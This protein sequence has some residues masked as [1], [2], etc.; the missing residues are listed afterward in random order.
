MRQVL[1]CDWN[2]VLSKLSQLMLSKPYFSHCVARLDLLCTSSYNSPFSP[3]SCTSLPSDSSFLPNLFCGLDA[4][5]AHPDLV[6][7]FLFSFQIREVEPSLFPATESSSSSTHDRAGHWS[8]TPESI[9]TSN[10]KCAIRELV[11]KRLRE[12]E[13]DFPSRRCRDIRS[14][15]RPAPI[16]R[17]Y[18]IS[19][20]FSDAGDVTR[21]SSSKGL[22][23]DAE[24]S[25]VSD[26][27]C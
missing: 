15:G 1:F 20:D 4:A 27:A 8:G 3:K 6:T 25:E 22:A 12:A 23:L 19:T 13:T 14:S 11:L 9:L 7:C 21:S 17:L 18:N 26:A 5:G 16:I 24:V 10:L 2:Q